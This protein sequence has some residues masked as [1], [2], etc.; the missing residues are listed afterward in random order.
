M[1]AVIVFYLGGQFALSALTPQ[2]AAPLRSAASLRGNRYYRGRRSRCFIKFRFKNLNS[3][4]FA[5]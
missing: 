5:G 2:S 4:T 3:L 1:T